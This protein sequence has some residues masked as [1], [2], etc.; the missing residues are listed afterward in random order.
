MLR[1]RSARYKRDLPDF[2]KGQGL[3]KAELKEP[4]RGQDGESGGL[5]RALGGSRRELLLGGATAVVS[6][7]FVAAFARNYWF[8]YDNF[9]LLTN[10]RFGRVD[11]WFRPHLDHWLTWTV[12]LSRGL[13]GLVGMHYWP[14]WYVPRLIGHALVAFLVWRTVLH[15]GADRKIAFAVYLILLVLAV[16]SF[17]D[18]LTAANYVLYPC[19]VVVSLLVSEVEAPRARHLV[20]VGVGLL[21]AVMANGYGIALLVAVA[22]VVTARRR[23]R[24]WLPA[25]V[26]PFVAVGAWYLRYRSQLPRHDHSLSPSFAFKAMTSSFD[27]VR[28]AVENT[29]GL[30]GPLAVLAVVAIAGL[31]VWLSYR[32]RLDM[33]DAIIALNLVFV[34]ATL[35]WARTTVADLAENSRYGY[36][37]ILML[38]LLFVPRLR[39]P[40]ARVARTAFAFVLVALVVFNAVSLSRRLEQIGRVSQSIRAR[41]ETTAALIAAGEPY[42]YNSTVRMSVTG[43]VGPRLMQELVNGGW[44][45]RRSTDAAV[46]QRA[47]ALMRGVI[48][49]DPSRRVYYADDHVAP[50]AVDVDDSGCVR[51]TKPTLVRLQVTGAGSFSVDRRA[52]VTWN[53]LRGTDEKLVEPGVIGLTR[54]VGKATVTV[55][56]GGGPTNICSLERVAKPTPAA[57]N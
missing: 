3:L 46:V 34:L 29:F 57:R 14:W 47:R 54:P 55:R 4:T 49:G 19:I 45:P 11:D 35:A 22:L 56:T 1:K 16:S 7:L 21:A 27:V 32:H 38:T 25:L 9:L 44:K 17:L 26:P 37:V 12:L 39:L 41:A 10:R 51:L 30:P 31:L 24:R 8:R 5:L 33:F 6:M 18:A 48:M 53:D 28:T 13:F 52:L 23:L 36:S 43:G 2:G 15:R 20:V 42:T 50:G 40:A